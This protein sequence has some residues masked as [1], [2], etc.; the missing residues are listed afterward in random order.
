[1]V[2]G[3]TVWLVFD[4]HRLPYH[5]LLVTNITSPGESVSSYLKLTVV[6]G[7]YGHLS[8]LKFAPILKVG[9]ITG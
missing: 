3:I 9:F 4:N 7:D 1:M 2:K 5:Y 8:S 6:Y